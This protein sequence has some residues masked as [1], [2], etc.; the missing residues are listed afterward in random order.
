MLPNFSEKKATDAAILLL[1][2]AGGR[3]KYI[4]LLK[5]LYLSEKEAFLEL[6]RSI[7]NDN[8]CSMSY[9]QVPSKTYDLVKGTT[10]KS[11]GYWDEFIN[12]PVDKHY[13]ELQGSPVDISELSES[14]EDIL[15]A[16]FL[17]YKDMDDFDLAK[18]TKGSE[19]IQTTDTKKSIP[20]PLEKILED[21]NYDESE[22]AGIIDTLEEEASIQEIFGGID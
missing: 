14:E 10:F 1:E 19:Y 11:E 2:L 20:T 8:Y 15:Q 9:G 22:I 6:G 4:R 17:K 13:V 18:E 21:L 3:M 16:I 7:T 5:L 12:S